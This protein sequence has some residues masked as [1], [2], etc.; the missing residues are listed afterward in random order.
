MRFSTY[1][2]LMI[3]LW[4]G[5]A[6]SCSAQQQS[7]TC[8]Q[9]NGHF[10]AEFRGTGVRVRIGALRHEGLAIRSCKA[11]LSW[12][13]GSLS[14]VE[15]A[16]EVDLDAFGVDFG[17]GAPVAAFQVKPSEKDCCAEY[18]LYSLSK[19]PRLLR[20][21]RGGSWFSAA[22]KDL[23]GQVEI[24]TDDADAVSR[25]D[26][27]NLAELDFAPKVIF[28]FVHGRLLDVSSEFADYF[29]RE[30]LKLQERVSSDDLREFKRSDGKLLSQTD[31]AERLHSLRVTKAKILEMVWCYLY[32]GR[33][34]RAWQALSDMWPAADAGRIH[35]LISSAYA[36]GIRAQIEGNSPGAG[37]RRKAAIFD[38][39]DLTG[40]RGADLLA[41]EPIVLT[42]PTPPET[43]RES[44]AELVLVIDSAGKVRSADAGKSEA[45][46]AL[47]DASAAWKF[48]PAFKNGRAVACRMRLAISNRQ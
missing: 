8:E 31:P 20:T 1:F 26:G 46:A 37:K 42:R 35:T 22:D 33:E 25:F 39:T 3:G 40:E 5:A 19:A 15:N 29:D 9:G 47:I 12:N 41:P 23:D 10:E 48:I 38:V 24:W 18:R 34:Q 43:S 21:I 2:I 32:S 17:L 14:V 27:L 13:N 11:S 30:L 45:N 36:H 16:D 4:A 28:R 44:D 6:G 7:P